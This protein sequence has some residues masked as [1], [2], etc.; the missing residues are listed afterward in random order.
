MFA[1]FCPSSARAEEPAGAEAGTVA[2]QTAT[3]TPSTQTTRTLPGARTMSSQTPAP[4]GL[5]I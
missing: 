1:L 5:K 3:A 4:V 2:T